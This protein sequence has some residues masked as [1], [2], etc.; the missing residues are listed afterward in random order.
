MAFERALVLLLLT[1][2]V[3]YAESDASAESDAEADAFYSPYGHLAY[4]AYGAAYPYHHRRAAYYS[5]Y[6]FAAPRPLVA[7]HGRFAPLFRPAQYAQPAVEKT[8]A[9][10]VEQPAIIEEPAVVA[11]AAAA[12]EPQLDFANHLKAVPA[13]PDLPVVAN[14]IKPAVHA[15]SAQPDAI[16][17]VHPAVPVAA[18]VP[19]P[20]VPT[21]ANP[22]V[23]TQYHSQD[24]FGNV[25]YGYA[26]PNSAKQESR[27]AYGN[28]IGAYS[29]VDATGFPKHVAY[30]ADD[31]GFRVTSSNAL[32]VHQVPD[33]F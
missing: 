30:V 5:P 25:A 7:G 20:L 16:P 26:N 14:S 8:A 24:E 3:A 19:S 27:D 1:V 12:P 10:I 9:A 33:Q 23:A 31:F 13:V 15:V 11:A 17:A 21:D 18:A 2:G 6:A 22:T 29:Y 32:P 4:G 28:V